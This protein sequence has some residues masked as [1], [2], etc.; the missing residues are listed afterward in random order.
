ML[1]NLGLGIRSDFSVGESTLQIP[2]IVKAAAERGINKLILT[3]TMTVSGVVKFTNLC[4]KEG[5]TPIIGVNVRVVLDPTYRKPKKNSGEEEKPNPHFFVRVFPKNEN[6]MKSILKMLSK[7]NS[8]DYFYYFSRI[9]FEDLLDMEDIEV[10]TCDLNSLFTMDNYLDYADRIIQRFGRLNVELVPINTPLFDIFNKRAINVLSIYPEQAVPALSYPVLYEKEGDAKTLEVL[11]AIVTNT[12][13]D[14]PYRPQQWVEDFYIQEKMG[15]SN[16]IIAILTRSKDRY[17]EAFYNKAIKHWKVCTSSGAFVGKYYEF[18]KQNIS[19]PKMAEDEFQELKNQCIIGWKEKIQRPILGFKPKELENYKERLRYELSILKKMGFCGYFLLVQDIVKWS[20]NQGIIVGPGRGSVGGSLVA[21]L[22]DITDV[23]PLRF[24][25]LFER[26]INPE[27]IDLPDA[28]LD[29][30]SSRRMEVVNY[31][32][33]KYGEDHVAGVSNYSTLASASALR[34]TGRVFGIKPYDLTCTKLVPKEHGNPISLEKAAEKVP[35]IDKFK[36]DNPEIWSHAIKLEGAMRGYGQHAA[37]IIVAD[38]VISNRASVETR[39][40]SAVVNWDKRVVED[41]GLVKVDILGLSTLDI[42]KKAA[43]RIYN[44]TGKKIVYTDLPLD[45][46]KVLKEFGKGNTIGVFQFESSG[47]RKL[48]TD[49][50]ESSDLTFDDLSAVTSLYRPGP[51]DAG[52]CDDYIAIRKG[53]KSEFYEHENIRPSLEETKSVIVYQEQVM[54]ISRDLC[55]FTLPEADHLRK[56]MGKKDMAKMKEWKDKFI[57]GAK[58]KSGMDGL[59]AATLWD[60]IEGFAA[61]AFNKSHSVEYSIISYWT[62]W[63]KTYY[64]L[65]FY[66]ACLSIVGEDKLKGIV[67]DAAKNG[68]K[69]LPPDINF[70][71]NDY[72]IKSGTEIVAPFSAIKGISENVGNYILKSR[73][74]AGGQFETLESFESNINT[75]K[76]NVRHRANLSK[77]GALYELEKSLPPT[78]TDRLKDQ[79]ELLPGIVIA[80]VKADRKTDVKDKFLRAKIIH[81]IN[82][83][84]DCKDCPLSSQPH[85]TPGMGNRAVKFMVVYDNPNYKEGKA[86]RIFTGDRA[87]IVKEVMKEYGI[88]PSEGYYTSLVKGVPEQGNKIGNAEII[89]CSK[90]IDREVELIKP[91]VII[92]LGT[93]SMKY[94]VPEVKKS[95]LELSGSFVYDKEKD[96]TI[97]FGINPSMLYFDSTRIEQLKKTF[98]VVS[99]IIS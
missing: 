9:G 79:I 69:V 33:D 65:H 73:K 20:K 5:I 97:V 40:G 92:T 78:H 27:R 77:V 8:K 98:E 59:N 89:Q 42:L 71:S 7:A 45:D 10:S 70:S 32:K 1:Q 29:F 48:L 67:T 85:P 96:A 83:L 63:L 2:T 14:A 30:M 43:D 75:T 28:D 90:Y 39:A 57:N 68:V 16:K 34:D 99:E 47:M 76:V 91:S 23:D 84:K 56:A 82:E 6:G 24:G 52:L 60:K 88:N 38:D 54:Q 53:L 35:D 49:L 80:T 15:L 12:H 4:K 51:L 26:F 41:W 19:L 87:T 86:D 50:A 55:G 36:A 81:T 62:M 18:N 46:P 66:A 61:Y 22:M 72:E 13:M 44:E 31:L 93:E 94:F 37:G 17:G 21:Y 25:L 58:D 3:D 11:N 74:K 95:S 64:P